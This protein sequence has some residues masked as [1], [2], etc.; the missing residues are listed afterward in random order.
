MKT[1]M[2]QELRNYSKNPILWIG[3]LVILVELVQILNPYLQ[4][5]YFTSEEELKEAEPKVLDDADIMEG[6]IVSSKQERMDI[7]CASIKEEMTKELGL[8][9]KEAN[10]LLDKMISQ[11]DSVEQM[12]EKIQALFGSYEKLNRSYR[13]FLLY[14]DKAKYHKGDLASVNEYIAGKL[15]E[16]TFSWYVSRK[17]ADFC[18]LYLCFFSTILLAFLYIRDTRKDMYELLHTKPINSFTYV[19]GKAAGGILVLTLVWSLF[20]LIFGVLC[21]YYGKKANLPISMLDFIRNAAVYIL[22]NLLM[23]VSVY[24]LVAMVFKNPLPAVP[25]LLLYIVYSNMGSIGPNGR[26]GYYGRPLA[27]MVRFPGTFLETQAPPMAFWNQIGLLGM[28][29]LFL[30]ASSQIWKRRRIH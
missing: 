14:Y 4:M 10:D 9:S 11:G 16:H 25:L 15:K 26:Y 5:H 13:S 24:T 2:K 21:V 19:A 8:S 27:I 29:V 7:A 22:P 23:I 18:G 17:F 12:D 1:I 30:L 20:T 3:V 6:Y 28:A